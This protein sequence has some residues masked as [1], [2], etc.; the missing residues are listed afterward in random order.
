[1][2]EHQNLQWL[3]IKSCNGTI[4]QLPMLIQII[5]MFNLNDCNG[6]LRSPTEHYIHEN[7]NTISKEIISEKVQ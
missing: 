6:S 5:E 2:V 3:T 4:K 1:M 7:K